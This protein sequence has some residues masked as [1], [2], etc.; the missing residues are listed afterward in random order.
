[1]NKHSIQKQIVWLAIIPASL[2]PLSLETLFLVEMSHM[3]ELSLALVAGLAIVTLLLG[4]GFYYLA[5]LAGRRITAP[6]SALNESL[7][8]ILK[9]DLKSQASTQITELDT[10]AQSVNRLAAQLQQERE[11][12]QKRIHE[13]T[14]ALRTKKER[15]ESANHN[16]RRFLAVASHELRQPL[17]ALNLYIAELQRIAIGTEQQHLVGQINHSVE[18]LTNMLNGLLDISKLDA[19]SIVPQIQTCSMAAMLAQISNNHSVMARIKNIRLVVRPCTCFVISDQQLLERI[20]MNLVSNAIRYTRPNGSVLVGCRRRGQ[21]VCIEVRDNGIGIAP[22][23]QEN[24]FR[25]FHQCTHPQLGTDSKGL[26][27]GLAIVDRLVK[28]LGH[29]LTLHSAPGKGTIFSLELPLATRTES[30]PVDT[31][32]EGIQSEPYGTSKGAAMKK[33][34][35]VD[36]DYLVLVSTAHILASWGHDVSTADSLSAVQKLLDKGCQWDLIISD[37]QLEEEVTGLDVVQAVRRQMDRAI[38]CILITGNTSLE[39]SNLTRLEGHHILNKPVRPA[40]L[41]SL[42]EF[43][44]KE[45]R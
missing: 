34:L 24:I 19:R 11:L 33:L 45:R 17:H 41:R 44:L 5:S 31:T 10:L 3:G 35:V 25:E 30:S 23:D 9:G 18:A 15:A 27:L 2:V 6:I 12:C 21:M 13:A 14:Q 36:D 20:L 8:D 7:Q 43:L 26:G 39:V 37:Y 38:P 40:K 16:A 4:G 28:L 1:M 29:K 32:V 22:A 42:V